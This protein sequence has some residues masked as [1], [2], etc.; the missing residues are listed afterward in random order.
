MA[1]DRVPRA[2]RGGAVP[3]GRLALLLLVAAAAGW[4][5]R[6]VVPGLGEGA[7]SPGPPMDL[8][9]QEPPPEPGADTEVPAIPVEAELQRLRT[10][11]VAQEQ[12]IQA[13]STS[14][15]RLGEAARAPEEPAAERAPA[16]QLSAVNGALRSAGAGALR[17]LELGRVHEG[18]LEEL[19]VLM[20]Q[21]DGSPGRAE[22]WDRGELVVVDGV[23]HLAL[24]R[25][26]DE[27]SERV[28]LPLPGL[29]RARL[30]GTDL[31]LVPDALLLAPARAALVRLLAGQRLEL[32]ALAGVRDGELLGLELVERDGTGAMLRHLW[33]ARAAVLPEGPALLLLDG[34]VTAQGVTRPFYRGK[35]HLPLP[36]ADHGRWLTDLA[37]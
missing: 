18:R 7:R 17:L 8:P 20:P 9:E 4:L 30:E 37:P 24:G 25:Q 12:R 2:G 27:R 3:A 15:T 26:L 14:L 16:T 6:D 22:S 19:L 34:D 13:L 32:L 36:G 1:T 21:A 29:E 5:A 35:L 33:A 10:L 28:E 23:A 31:L 11:V